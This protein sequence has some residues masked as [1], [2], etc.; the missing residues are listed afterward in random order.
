MPRK[1]SSLTSLLGA[2]GIAALMGNLYH[3]PSP[4][5]GYQNY[6]AGLQNALNQGV[7]NLGYAIIQAAATTM[8]PVSASVLNQFRSSFN[9][10]HETIYFLFAD[11]R[12]VITSAVNPGQE[13]GQNERFWVNSGF[14]PEW[15]EEQEAHG[16]TF[17]GD[18]HSHPTTKAGIE[19]L[20]RSQK[21]EQEIR[22]RQNPDLHFGPY[23][24]NG[25]SENDLASYSNNVQQS[26]DPN[27]PSAQL[28][29]KVLNQAKIHLV[30]GLNT[31]TFSYQVRAFIYLDTA[32]YGL[33]LNLNLP[34][35]QCWVPLNRIHR[36]DH[37]GRPLQW[38]E[39]GVRSK[40]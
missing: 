4:T 39:L 12:E 15:L 24:N 19:E 17:V 32:K 8:V 7:C 27:S 5:L 36:R 11:K 9:H 10:D 29:Q 33:A 6:K 28:N 16:L 31:S 21:A 30:G 2:V 34:G 37:D 40:E 26:L 14:T 23:E 18:Y 25:P 1:S 20:L 35:K 13:S 38:V 3:H 22:L